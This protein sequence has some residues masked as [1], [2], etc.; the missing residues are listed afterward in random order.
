MDER[1]VYKQTVVQMTL[2]TTGLATKEAWGM[3]LLLAF[4]DYCKWRC[5]VFAMEDPCIL[6]PLLSEVNDPLSCVSTLL[7]AVLHA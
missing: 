4:D 5:Q 1:L 2:R 3:T 7:N 6:S